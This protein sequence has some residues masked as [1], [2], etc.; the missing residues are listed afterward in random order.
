MRVLVAEDEID[1]NNIPIKEEQ[2]YYIN[3]LAIKNWMEENNTTKPPRSDQNKD[4]TVE[5]EEIKL[6]I[7]LFRIRQNLIKKYKKLESEEE[8]AEYRRTLKEKVI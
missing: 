4:G 6:G 1:M 2:L 7:A 3:I 8:K 5:K